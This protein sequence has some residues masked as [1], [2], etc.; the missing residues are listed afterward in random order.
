MV[1]IYPDHNT[2]RK[3]YKRCKREICSLIELCGVNHLFHTV[4][5]LPPSICWDENPGNKQWRRMERL[6]KK[7]TRI[8]GF[9]RVA[10][11]HKSGIPHF[12]LLVFSDTSLPDFDRLYRKYYNEGHVALPEWAQ[13][14]G[15]AILSYAK[16]TGFGKTHIRTSKYNNSKAPGGYL[17][18]PLR[19]YWEGKPIPPDL[20]EVFRVEYWTRNKHPLSEKVRYL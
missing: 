1:N 13:A 12:H 11:L 5:T 9:I 4:L 16:E 2:V 18:K 10:H 17:L 14:F 6:L 8:L 19:D 7:D 3:S 20:W 15:M